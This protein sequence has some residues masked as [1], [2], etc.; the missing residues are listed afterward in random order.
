MKRFPWKLIRKSRLADIHHRNRTLDSINASLTERL[1]QHMA[2]E[3]RLEEKIQALAD[4]C[5][6]VNVSKLENEVYR[7]K[8]ELRKQGD[9]P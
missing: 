2:Y 3:I 6:L 9:P 1:D 4:K 8:E 7:L 5:S